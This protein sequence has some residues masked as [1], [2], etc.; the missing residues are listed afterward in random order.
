MNKNVAIGHL[1]LAMKLMGV[2]EKDKAQCG[3]SS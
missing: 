2:T 3:S 1:N